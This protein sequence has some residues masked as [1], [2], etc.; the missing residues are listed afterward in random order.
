MYLSRT[1]NQLASCMSLLLDCVEPSE[2][3]TILTNAQEKYLKQIEE[4]DSSIQG[5]DDNNYDGNTV[6]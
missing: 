3:E 2:M 6:C 1:G 4:I 5:S